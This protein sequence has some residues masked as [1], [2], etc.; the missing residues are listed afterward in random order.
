MIDLYLKAGSKSAMTLALKTA[1]FI[2]DPDSGAL[3]HPDAALDVIGTI[4]QPTGE[5]S[6]VDGQEVPVT[7]PVS[8]YH[9]NVRTTSDELATALDAQRTYPVTPVRVWA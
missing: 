2:Q 3:Y 4:Y 7:A 1:G 8:G 6:L 5:T 9:V